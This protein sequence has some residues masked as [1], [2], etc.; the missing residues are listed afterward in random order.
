M[1]GMFID[2][3]DAAIARRFATFPLPL[4]VEELAA[5][6]GRQDAQRSGARLR[7]FL[8]RHPLMLKWARILFGFRTEN[9]LADEKLEAIRA[10]AFSR[11]LLPGPGL[12]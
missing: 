2:Q 12:S 6:V 3:R 9:G 8:S 7:F 5:A 10:A 4:P 1:T 11:A